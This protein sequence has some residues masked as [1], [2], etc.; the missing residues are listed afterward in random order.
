[1]LVYMKYDKDTR[2]KNDFSDFFN[3]MRNLQTL[4]LSGFGMLQCKGVLKRN[5]GMDSVQ[6]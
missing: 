4:S 2:Q 5:E 1:M 6:R 3:K